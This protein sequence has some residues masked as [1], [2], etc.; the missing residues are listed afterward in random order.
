LELYLLH[1]ERIPPLF[2]WN[3]EKAHPQSSL[4]QYRWWMVVIGNLPYLANLTLLLKS[5]NQCSVYCKTLRL[6][7]QKKFVVHTLARASRCY[8][9]S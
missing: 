9:S 4:P 2:P 8:A 3:G 1:N 7:R 5:V 6:V